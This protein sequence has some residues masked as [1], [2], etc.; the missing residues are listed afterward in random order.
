MPKHIIHVNRQHISMNAKDNLNRP[1]YTIKTGSKTRYAREVIMNGPSKM[2]YD[3]S[4]LKCG[5]R[6]WIETY[7]DITLVDEMSFA[8]A[9]SPKGFV[10]SRVV[11]T[12]NNSELWMHNK[13]LHREDGPA[14]YDSVRNV[15]KFYINGEQLTTD[16][17]VEKYGKHN[18]SSKE[19]TLMLMRLQND[20]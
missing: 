15:H 6:A 12:S 1:V 5:A 16:E 11:K 4:Q 19:L 9:R 7:S 14:L 20:R 2:V 3:G 8:E 18:L 13:K 17:W 10:K